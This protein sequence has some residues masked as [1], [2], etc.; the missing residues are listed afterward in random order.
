MRSCEKLWSKILSINSK[1]YISDKVLFKVDLKATEMAVINFISHIFDR[2][3]P[4]GFVCKWYR[5]SLYFLN[6]KILH[7]IYI[8]YSTHIVCFFKQVIFNFPINAVIW[9]PHVLYMV[10]L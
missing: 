4:A 7:N 3:L 1:K 9:F 2:H 10:S 8:H 6:M 5:V